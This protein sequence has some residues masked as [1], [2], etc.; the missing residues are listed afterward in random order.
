MNPPERL[1][2]AN[3]N[4]TI[5]RV[6]LSALAVCIYLQQRKLERTVPDLVDRESLLGR[7]QEENTK[8]RHDLDGA[9]AHIHDQAGSSPA[10]SL[11]GKGSDVSGALDIQGSSQSDQG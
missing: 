9:L 4:L 10:G 8:L 5:I 2:R 11:D 7:L 6:A 1:A 3:A